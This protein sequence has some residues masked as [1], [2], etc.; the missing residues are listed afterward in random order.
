MRS[1]LRRWRRRLRNIS[2]IA[3]KEASL[4]RH[5][6]TLFVSVLVLPAF[7]VAGYPG[8][9]LTI[10]AVVASAMA[11]LWLVA[12]RMTSSASAAWVAWASVALTTPMFFHAFTIYPDG[13]GAGSRAGPLPIATG[14]PQNG[15]TRRVP[16]RLPP[17]S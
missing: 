12:W 9:L 10:V 15:R 13:A 1:W 3:Y 4:L 17:A 11:L 2:A 7:A 16:R 8:A 5:D 6:Q 14:A